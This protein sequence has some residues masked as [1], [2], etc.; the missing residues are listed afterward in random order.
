MGAPRASKEI[1]TDVSKSARHA[2]IVD[3]LGREPALRVKEMAQRYGV[4]SETIRRDLSELT[5]KGL[6]NRT[7]G[8]AV[9]VLSE[10][11]RLSDREHLHVTERK[12]VAECAA[13]LI[14]P[15][16][17][18]LVG[19]GITTKFFARAL[20]GFSQPLT[21]ITTSF[22]VATEL[23]PSPNIRVFMLS[24]EFNA[25]EGQV[26]GT[27]TL[28]CLS[29]FR[30]TKAII[31]ASG[32]SVDGISDAAIPAG[33]LYESMSKRAAQTL[34]LADNSKFGVNALAAHVRWA[35]EVTLVTNQRP[36]ADLQAAIC[37]AGGGIIVP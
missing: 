14:R 22:G 19:G 7:Y 2:K 23:A 4:S 25:D 28:E 10:E 1:G 16:D 17:V 20:V 31:G 35:P 5:E 8:G 6:I 26:E 30:G 34:V 37:G 11:P 27:E 13:A 24:G 18:L 32:V 21:V 33:R 12:Q 3:D 36:P 29:R 15:D 9:R